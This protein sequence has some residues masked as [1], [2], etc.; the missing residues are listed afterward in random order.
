MDARTQTLVQVPS[1]SVLLEGSLDGPEVASGIVLFAH[2]SG[3]SRHSPRNRYVAEVLLGSGFA[4]LLLDLLT[5]EEDRDVE[6]RFD[7]A[8]LADRLGD[9]L[10]FVQSQPGYRSL[11]VGLF[12]AS[13]GAAAALRV[14]AAH[15]DLIEAVVSRGGRPDL[16]GEQALA[17]VH[18]PTLLIVGGADRHVLSLNRAAMA[19]LAGEASLVVVPGAAHLFEETGALEAVARHASAWFSRHLLRPGVPPPRG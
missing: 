4:T 17:N 16:A 14:A 12:G 19:R 15:P 9:A 2:G 3:S 5:A 6:Q 18:A 13:T 8:L 1:G 11:P 7:I 10:T